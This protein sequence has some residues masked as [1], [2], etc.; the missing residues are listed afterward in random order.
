[1]TDRTRQ[2]L[3]RHGPAVVPLDTLLRRLHREGRSSDALIA[4]CEALEQA[5][6]SP[7]PQ[8]TTLGDDVDG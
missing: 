7:L 8:S 3:D 1:M 4:I 2:L 6:R 5:Q